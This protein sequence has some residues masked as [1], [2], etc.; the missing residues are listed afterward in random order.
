[1]RTDL[2]Q[3]LRAGGSAAQIEAARGLLTPFLR[4][5]LVGY[6]YAY[7]EPPGAQVLHNNPLFVRPTTLRRR[8]SRAFSTSGALLNSS[9]SAS[10]PVAALICSVRSRICR[11][12]WRRWRGLYCS[13][14][15]Q[16]LIWQ[17]IV[18]EFLVN[19]WCR[20]GGEFRPERCTP[21]RFISGRR[22]TPDP[23]C[24]GCCAAGK[25]AG[26]SCRSNAPARL[27]TTA[28]ACRTRKLR[29]T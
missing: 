23:I 18:P 24:I 26:H 20:A 15:V 9:A 21:P 2:T 11:M 19:A 8:R 1:M 7:Y 25:S 3:I 29:R 17:Q 28:E 6:N 27:E 5:T 13:A 4:D 10:P 16:A 22:R 14:K 12:R